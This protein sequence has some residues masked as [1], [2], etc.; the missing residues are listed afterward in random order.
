MIVFF[1]YLVRYEIDES[2]PLKCDPETAMIEGDVWGYRIL[3]KRF[4]K[5]SSA[6]SKTEM[7]KA[8]KKKS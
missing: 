5:R 2:D 4:V 6:S 7:K 3:S 8:T 1:K